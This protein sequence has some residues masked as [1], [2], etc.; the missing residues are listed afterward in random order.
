MNKKHDLTGKRFGRLV[1][2]HIS[3]SK[4]YRTTWRCV[5]DCGNV[6]DV[7]QQNLLDGHVTSCGCKLRDVNRSKIINYNNSQNKES[8]METKTRLYRIWIGMKAR[9]EQN[10][11]NYGERGIKVCQR[12]KESFLS[13]KSWALVN[14]YSDLL[15]IDR[16]DVNGDYCPENCRWVNMSLQ[17][18]NKR[19]TSRNKSGVVGVSYNSNHK[20]WVATISKDKV[21]HYI[22]CFKTKEE[23]IAARMEAEKQYY[24]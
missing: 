10:R 6:K 18:Y 13:F 12:W 17:E 24:N 11:H 8:H 20:R 7:L 9:C 21:F 19:P 4:N 16:I 14:G 5:C 3:K 22:G 1:V 15:S 23:A 2:Q